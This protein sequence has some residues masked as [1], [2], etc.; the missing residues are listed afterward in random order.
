MSIALWIAKKQQLFHLVKR[1]SDAYGGDEVE[2]LR[3]YAKE[4]VET[5]K[6]DLQQAINCFEVLLMSAPLKLLKSPERP[7]KTYFCEHCGYK[8]PFCYFNLGKGCSNIKQT[9]LHGTIKERDE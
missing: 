7:I 8:P 6:E 4:L 3:E 9:V 2:W 5:N 1:V